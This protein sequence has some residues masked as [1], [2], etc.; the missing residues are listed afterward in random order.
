MFKQNKYTN[1]Y[2]SII[3]KAKNEN[4][5]DT[6]RYYEKH[7]IIPKALGGTNESSNL[8]KLTAKEHYVAHLLLMKMVITKRAQYQ[9]AGAYQYMSNIRND[10][11]KQRYSSKLYNYHKQIRCKLLAEK[12]AGRGNHMWGKQHSG[13]TRS[14]ISK[15]R[16][17]VNTNTPKELEI[18]KA[19]MLN[20]N[21][22]HNPSIRRKYDQIMKQKARTWHLQTP[23]GNDLWT[24]NLKQFCIMQKL[25]QGN[26]ITYGHTK[27]WK[28]IR[29]ITVQ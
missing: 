27:G 15:A 2:F 11:T 3:T 29:E 4:R 16:K 24:K 6:S 5:T 8:V 1:W 26:F 21:P 7:H 28:L 17:G 22:M 9:M 20:N 19:Y 18:R 23:A 25:N 14:K 13:L 12:M 10:Y